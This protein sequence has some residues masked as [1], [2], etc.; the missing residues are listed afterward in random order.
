MLDTNEARPDIS[1][2]YETA[3]H[4]SRILL[5][6]HRTG[7]AD[8][9]VAAGWSPTRIGMALLR[10]HSEW[11]AAAKP[12]RLSAASVAQ[13][14]IMV[15]RDDNAAQDSATARGVRYEPPKTS[16]Q[17]RAQAEADK[18]FANEL[19]LLA[20][21]LK[22]RATVREQLAPWAAGRGIASEVVAEA[23]LHWLSPTCPH[24]DGHGLR[25]VPN[26][27]ALSARQCSKCQ[28]TGNKPAP[29]GSGKVLAHIDY[30]LGVARGS[31]TKRLRSAR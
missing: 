22:S 27:P 10:L 28:G 23:L 29:Q 3:T 26:S 25:K 31:L 8:V 16:A 7:A 1:E 17:Q 11:T 21:G 30:C 14:A 2:R 19:R 9:L 5:E 13:L 18:W 6:E 24:C 4:A 12:K 20:I 15:R